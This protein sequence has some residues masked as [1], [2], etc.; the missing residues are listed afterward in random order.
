VIAVPT[1]GTN[2]H[3][4]DRSGQSPTWG[5]STDIGG[6]RARFPRGRSVWPISNVGDLVVHQADGA[7]DFHVEDR[8]GQS[9]TWGTSSDIG[10]R[11]ARFPR[12][13][14]VWPISHVGDLD[15]HRRNGAL[16]FHVEDRSGQSPTWGTST[17]IGGRR[18]RFPR[19][20]SVWPLPT[21]ACRR[22]PSYFARARHGALSITRTKNSTRATS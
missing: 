21:W 6:R 18:A 11:R 20:R 13:R 5:T 14:S 15:G 7:L 1:W 3:V 22:E 8:S 2:F 12:G 17:D 16:D 4:E 19:G 9:P 10:G